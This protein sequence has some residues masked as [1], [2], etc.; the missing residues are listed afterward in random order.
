M[1][2]NLCWAD[3]TKKPTLKSE[4]LVNYSRTLADIEITGLPK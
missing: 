2:H 3:A 4:R 1:Y